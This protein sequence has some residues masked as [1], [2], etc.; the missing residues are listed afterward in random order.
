MVGCLSVAYAL[1]LVFYFK[2]EN[3]VLFYLLI[4]G[5]L[6]YLWQIVS[7]IH[8]IWDITPPKLPD[9]TFKTQPS[10]DIYITVAGEPLDVVKKTVLAA[11]GQ[12]YKNFKVYVLNDGYVA[13]KTGWEE[14]ENLAISLGA[15][16]ITRKV[17]G[18][19]KAGNINN[20]MNF[21]SGEFILILDVDHVP[22]KNFIKKTINYFTD[23]KLAFLQT[24]QYYENFLENQVTYASWHQ[25]C[26]FF[27]P[28]CMGKNRVNAVTMSGTNMMLRREAL[29]E[30]GG[31]ATDSI[32]ED[33]LTGL[34][35]HAL[36]W[37][38]LYL[39]EVLARGLAPLDVSSYVSQQF[40]WAR[41]SLEVLFKHN[42]IFM[43]GLSIAQRIEYLSSTSYFF[44]GLV[45]VISAVL[46]LIYFYFGQV[47]VSVSGMLL[48]SV[49]LP[50]I[51][52]VVWMLNRYS[53]GTFTYSAVSF[54]LS[55]FW[56]HI[57]A[58]VAT[59]LRRK[60]GFVVTSK[61]KGSGLGW[62]EAGRICFPHVFFVLFGVLGVAIAYL[63]EGFVPA[64]TNNFSW[65]LWYGLVF[66]PFVGGVVSQMFPESS[67]K[68]KKDRFRS[69]VYAS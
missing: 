33:L 24:P 15:F 3:I 13:K 9:F 5:Q 44:S 51:V 69:Q 56:V 48:A 18:G 46:P 52:S 53:G 34:R 25:Q 42:P 64:L 22:A 21:S 67:F 37:K 4:I 41:G 27:G 36:G 35:M 11:L 66:T 23:P 55:S 19:A 32:A 40:R 14:V 49:F 57:A 68:Q 60:N 1:L 6:F 39:P 47:P 45:V 65:F 63:R 12:N 7:F 17:P 8:T 58:V 31:M 29:I 61:Q 59:M 54:S 62:L 30:A 26:L 2:P 43:K 28:I 20:A 50:Y 10:V 38:S 16:C